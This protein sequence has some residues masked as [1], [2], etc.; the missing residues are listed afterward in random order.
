MEKINIKIYSSVAELYNGYKLGSIDL[1]STT[2]NSNIEE[3]I[4]T[5]GFNLRE[6]YGREF[7]YLALNVERDAMSNIEVRQAINYAIDKQD[8]VNSVY[9]GNYFTADFPLSYG[10]YLYNKESSDYEYN[11][12]RSKQILNDNGWTYTNKY[13]QKKIENRYVRLKFNLLVN[14]YNGQR[15]EVA[16]KIREKLEDIGIQ[17]NVIAIKDRTFDRYIANKDYDILLTGVTVGLSPNLNRYFGEGNLANYSNNEANGILNDI[18]NIADTNIL[19]E[20]Y[21]RLQSI[22]QEDRAYIGL[23]FNKMSLIYGKNVSGTI[24]PTWYNLFYNIETWYRK[25]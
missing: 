20:K 17:V 9:G 25:K 6:T 2:K 14:S 4:G 24:N 18:K 16:N 5:I 13:W 3:N 8:I 19:K 10:S 21:N 12:D 22:F 23:Y 11:P 15:V 1:L 7:D